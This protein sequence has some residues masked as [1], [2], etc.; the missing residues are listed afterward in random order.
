MRTMDLLNVNIKPEQQFLVF[1]TKI[2]QPFHI[3]SPP[4]FSEQFIRDSKTLT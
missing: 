4:E 3:S 1:P 2:Y